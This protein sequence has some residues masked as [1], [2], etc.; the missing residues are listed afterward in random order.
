MLYLPNTWKICQDEQMNK[1]YDEVYDEAKA[2]GL[3]NNLHHKRPLHIHKSVKSWGLC[4]WKLISGNTF[5]C[6]VCINE[7][8]LSK[9]NY[10][11]ARKVIVHEMAHV[12]TPRSH[13]NNLWRSVGDKLGKKWN[14]TV[15]RTNSY[16]GLNLREEETIN[17][18]IECPECHMQWKYARA[19]KVVKNYKH[20]KC[21][22]CHVDLIRSK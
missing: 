16:E 3:I 13:H 18:I 10:D 12:A 7:E 22:K 9:K 17:Y 5:D 14:I 20:Y 11:V 2:L 15:Q 1:I 19:G 8:I 6:A 21:P 4:K